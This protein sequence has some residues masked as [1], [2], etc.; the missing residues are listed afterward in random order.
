MMQNG[1]EAEDLTA[2]GL[3]EL[4]RVD[5]RLLHCSVSPTGTLRRNN[6][7]AKEIDASL[8]RRHSARYIDE[9]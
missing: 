7:A 9:R 3:S 6:S 5:P 1:L 4:R 2:N 8:A